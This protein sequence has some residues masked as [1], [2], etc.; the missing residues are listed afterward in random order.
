MDGL[1]LHSRECAQGT[2]KEQDTDYILAPMSRH[3]L[4]S[5]INRAANL[6]MFTSEVYRDKLPVRSMFNFVNVS[7]A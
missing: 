5:N 2:A 4:D 6:P 3:F 1:F 7:S